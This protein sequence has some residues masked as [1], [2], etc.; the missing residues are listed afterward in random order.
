MRYHKQ[1]DIILRNIFGC[2]KKMHNED[3][4]TFIASTDPLH[5]ARTAPAPLP[6]ATGTTSPCLL[7]GTWWR[8]ELRQN[9][10]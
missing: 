2:G 6:P 9:H 1:T 3:E 8:R 10:I 5:I 4:A 7:K